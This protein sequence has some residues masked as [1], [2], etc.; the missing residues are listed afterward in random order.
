MLIRTHAYTPV[1]R[2]VHSRRLRDYE[3]AGVR[4][5]LGEVRASRHNRML[6]DDAMSRPLGTSTDIPAMLCAKQ[7]TPSSPIVLM[8]RSF[9]DPGRVLRL[10][11]EHDPEIIQ[12]LPTF[13]GSQWSRGPASWRDAEAW[14]FDYHHSAHKLALYAQVQESGRTL[15]QPLAKAPCLGRLLAIAKALHACPS[16]LC[17]AMVSDIST[18]YHP[19]QLR[20]INQLIIEEC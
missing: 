14:S 4:L 19:T 20:V 3:N 10:I 13:P 9:L 7:A 11:L 15:L 2:Y 8:P 16:G 12:R 17:Y 6:I 5:P 18:L 1:L